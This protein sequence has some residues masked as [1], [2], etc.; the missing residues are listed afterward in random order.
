MTSASAWFAC[1]GTG[2][3]RT[4]SAATGPN[5]TFRLTSNQDRDQ[6]DKTQRQRDTRQIC[7]ES[8]GR[9]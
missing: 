1:V 7:L 4:A 8:T 2:G 9:G 5:Y 6:R 3:G